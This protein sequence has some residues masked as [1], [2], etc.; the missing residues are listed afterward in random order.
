MTA[1]SKNSELEARFKLRVS[2]LIQILEA[3]AKEC[4][5]LYAMSFDID[6]DFDYYNDVFHDVGYQLMHLES[7]IGRGLDELNEEYRKIKEN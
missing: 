5:D 1:K 3:Q 6:Y 7:V 2:K 4:D